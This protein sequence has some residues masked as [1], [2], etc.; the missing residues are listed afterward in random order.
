MGNSCSLKTTAD[1][2]IEL[3]YKDLGIIYGDGNIELR[4]SKLF[5]LNL[6]LP[7][8]SSADQAVIKDATLRHKKSVAN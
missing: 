1:N 8:F 7:L 6:K 5:D 3:D 2:K 4:A